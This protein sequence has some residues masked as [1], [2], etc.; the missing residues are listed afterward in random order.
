MMEQEI[1]AIVLPEVQCSLSQPITVLT[2]TT[3]TTNTSSST[4]TTTTD[5]STTVTTTN[6]ISSIT[7]DMAWQNADVAG[8]DDNQLRIS[9]NGVTLRDI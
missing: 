7:F 8:A 9:Y 3:N 2:D 4:E 5:V 1:C 6:E